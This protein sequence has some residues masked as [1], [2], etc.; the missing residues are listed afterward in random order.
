MMLEV[1]VADG[2]V[3][4]TELSQQALEDAVLIGRIAKTILPDE[5]LQQIQ[6]YLQ[7]LDVKNKAEYNKALA[8]VKRGRVKNQ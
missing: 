1:E 2:R 6:K 5:S 4:R 8:I 3:T 7:Y